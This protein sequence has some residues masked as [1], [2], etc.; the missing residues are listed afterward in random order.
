MLWSQLTY[1]LTNNSI[2]NE[3]QSLVVC[4]LFSRPIQAD[5]SWPCNYRRSVCVRRSGPIKS[6]PSGVTWRHVAQMTNVSVSR[7]YNRR[8]TARSSTALTVTSPGGRGFCISYPADPPTDA[9][10]DQRWW[11]HNG[12]QRSGN[13]AVLTIW[14][15]LHVGLVTGRVYLE[16]GACC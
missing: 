6:T 7:Q 3:T 4:A 16:T 14:S 8:A 15:V 11:E 9:T 5:K 10:W 12:N 13:A 1:T 2:L